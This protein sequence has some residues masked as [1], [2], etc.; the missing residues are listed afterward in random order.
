M[1]TMDAAL[2][3]RH[4]AF[5][6]TASVLLLLS[7]QCLGGGNYFVSTHGDNANPGSEAEPW[8]TIQKAADTV[9]PGDSV[10]VLEGSYA[11][12]RVAV[13]RSGRPDLPITY[14]ARGKVV[15]KGFRVSAD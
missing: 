4:W 7:G 10:T 12:Q 3:H 1:G 8:K 5:A 13:G 9:S 14:Q 2:K 15:M 11:D 6:G